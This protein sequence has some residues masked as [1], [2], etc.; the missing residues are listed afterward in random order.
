MSNM[1]PLDYIGKKRGEKEQNAEVLNRLFREQWNKLQSNFSSAKRSNVWKLRA[2]LQ[3]D[4]SKVAQ[5]NGTGQTQATQGQSKEAR[6]AHR[7]LPLFH[8]AGGRIQVLWLADHTVSCLD[9]VRGKR[10]PVSPIEEAQV[11]LCLL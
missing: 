4:P 8:S 7:A 6:Q 3:N 11:S 1:S 9:L 2:E 5:R 10:K